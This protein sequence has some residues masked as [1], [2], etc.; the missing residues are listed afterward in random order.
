MAEASC[1]TCGP[2]PTPSFEL[3]RALEPAAPS[4]AA[5][6]RALAAR[7]QTG[8]PPQSGGG[9]GLDALDVVGSLDVELEDEPPSKRAAPPSSRPAPSS[10]SPAS[11]RSG[12]QPGARRAEAASVAPTKEPTDAEVGLVAGFGDPPFEWLPSVKYAIRV[13]RRRRV[14]AALVEQVRAESEGARRAAQRDMGSLLES[15]EARVG[16]D[17]EVAALLQPLRDLFG[18]VQST[19]EA[20]ARSREQH[21]ADDA[22]LAGELRAGEAAREQLTPERRIAQVWVEDVTATVTRL[23]G[24]LARLSRELTVAHEDAAKAAGES[25]FAPPEHARRITE[26]ESTRARTTQEIVEAEQ[27]LASRR[28]T[29]ADV[30]RRI[31]EAERSIANVHSRRSALAR[32]ARDEEQ[33]GSQA[34]QSADHARL[35]ATEAALRSL[36]DDEVPRLTVDEVTRFEALD[37][38]LSSAARRRLLHERALVAHHPEAFRRGV[39]LLASGAA[40]LLALIVLVARLL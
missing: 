1:P 38:T 9:P 13:L 30:D 10:A 34:V 28:S 3:E 24:D 22:A 16:D 18:Q 39:T 25:D 23:K 37:A 35:D 17:E 29:L 20:L 4:S 7:E 26:L 40:A 6:R 2:A 19:S 12:G 14:L 32:R 5:Q 33:A 11:S 21:R 15:F 8:S 31:A 36:A 27:N